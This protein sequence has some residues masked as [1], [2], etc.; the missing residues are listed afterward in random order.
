[1]KTKTVKVGVVYQ[2]KGYIEVE[3]PVNLKS[4]LAILDYVQDLED[5]AGD[6]PLPTNPEYLEGSFE[7][8]SI[9]GLC[10]EEIHCPFKRPT[11][12]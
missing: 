6:L 11:K 4:K 2:V 9:D 1:M 7:I 8:D 5:H 12:V 3:V 10:K